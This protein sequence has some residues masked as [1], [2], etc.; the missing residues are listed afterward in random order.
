MSIWSTTN[1]RIQTY[2]GRSQPFERD[3]AILKFA[4]L[5]TYNNLENWDT[6]KIKLVNYII[7]ISPS[8]QREIN[9]NSDNIVTI[10]RKVW[11]VLPA[12][13]LGSETSRTPGRKRNSPSRGE[14]RSHPRT[15]LWLRPCD[16]T[17]K[18]CSSLYRAPYIHRFC[19]H[20][21][22]RRPDRHPFCYRAR[23][24]CIVPAIRS[25]GCAPVS[26]FVF[27]RSR[28][29]FTSRSMRLAYVNGVC[30]ISLEKHC[31]S[32]RRKK[33]ISNQNVAELFSTIGWIR[34]RTVANGNHK[35]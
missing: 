30:L 5:V 8:R 24:S 11:A 12:P 32:S 23:R 1:C 18:I 16:V 21:P 2:H 7:C 14:E 20:R 29:G 9:S 22:P 19:Q 35:F 27:F 6:I 17:K 34:P 10:L 28:S 31:K 13:I 26:L 4:K 33:S 15:P 3:G 25:R